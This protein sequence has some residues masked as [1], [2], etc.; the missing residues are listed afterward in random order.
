MYTY[1]GQFIDHDLTAN[2]DRD[3]SISDIT[4]PDLKPVPP[5][6]VTLKLRNLRRPTLDLD[7]VYGDG[8]A[9]IDEDSKDAGSTSARGSASAA[10]RTT[11]PIRRS[12]AS[13][14]RPKATSTATCRASGRCWTRA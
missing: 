7:S 5:D 6:D 13:R 8:P 4:R 1:W 2:T 10:T 12:L 11:P 9:I 14:S 3:S